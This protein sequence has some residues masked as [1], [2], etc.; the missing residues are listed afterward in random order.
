MDRVSTQL[1]PHN[2]DRVELC[3]LPKDPLLPTDLSEQQCCGATIVWISWRLE[4]FFAN[5]IILRCNLQKCF[6]KRH[7]YDCIVVVH[8]TVCKALITLAMYFQLSLSYLRHQIFFQVDIDTTTKNYAPQTDAS[9][10]LQTSSATTLPS[11]TR[12]EFSSL[13]VTSL[14]NEQTNQFTIV[15][16]CSA[17][18]FTI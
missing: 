8:V 13:F 5:Y 9:F 17:N 6:T 4:W 16:S 10:S 18:C 11:S 14:Q 1:S 2:P 3:I 12:N 7:N 15:A